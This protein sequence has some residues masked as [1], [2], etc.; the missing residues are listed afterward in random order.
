[1]APDHRDTILKPA[2]PDDVATA[3]REHFGDAAKYRVAMPADM[4]PDGTFGEVWFIFNETHLGVMGRLNGTPPVLL[5]RRAIEDVGELTVTPGLS[6]AVVEAGRGGVRERLLRVSHAR[7]KDFGDAVRL[8]NAWIKD[9]AWKP[10]LMDE[11]RSNC[12]KCG[13]PLP[14]TMT[15][16]P[17]CM[18]KR[19]M[20]RKVLAFLTPY[21]LEVSLLFVY[22]IA[23]TLVGLVNPYLGKIMVDDVIKPLQ[24]M[25]WLPLLA[26][27]MAVMYTL[28]SV[29]DILT[30]RTSS[31]IGTW[32]VYDVRARMF[33]R[34]QELSLSFHSKHTP[35]ALITRVNQDTGQLQ[36]LL[37]DFVPYGISSILTAIGI[38]A[39]LVYLSWFLTLFV[40]IPIV[41]MIVFVWK[42]FP[43][44]HVYWV[45][46]FER[47]SRLVSFVDNVV[48]GFRVVKVFAQERA[49][50][51]RFDRR[52]ADFRDA[53]YDAEVRWA[54]SMPLLH[55]IIMTSTPIVW[56]VGGMLA[57]QGRMT[58]GEIFAYTGYIGMFFRPVF[59]LTRLAQLI[60][61]TLAAAGR[62]FD[63]ID[64]EPEI[65]DAPD[66]VSM[67]DIK[68]EIE[69]R[70]VSFGYDAVKPVLQG[71]SL[72]IAPKEMVGLVGHSGAGKSTTI[73][74]ICRLFDVTSGQIL[75]DGVDVRKIKCNDLRR[76]I[77]L[78]MQET[79]LLHGTIAENIAYAR[80][81]AT[82]HDIIRAAKAAN[83]HDFIIAKPDGYDTE[84]AQGGSNLSAGEKQRLSIARAIL[85]DP[86]ILILDEATA[87]VDLETEKQIQEAIARMVKERTT[88][89][90]AHRLSTLR[91]ATR[92][93]V[94]EKGKV[95][96]QGTHE[97]L[98]K[99]ETG[100]YSRLAKLHQE[101]SNVRAVDR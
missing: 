45:R 89:A 75:V 99:N 29:V 12:P 8:I 23:N 55:V 17:H 20:I 44:F 15:V 82:T 65:A 36:A 83:A 94:M 73:N 60:P 95:V 25:G 78:V 43:R 67:P 101:T 92:L 69:L 56:L 30:G 2:L 41:G 96:E 97:E 42:V 37:V 18:D 57:F 33:Q 47:R 9:K 14:D 68:G 32:A 72:K 35:G 16:C 100:V 49:E 28:Q 61:N 31:R 85:C 81:E 3:A 71:V 87:S 76:Q 52:S 50:N 86:R 66:A 77:G 98:L 27:A 5:D 53:T 19:Q 6:S 11:R 38:L 58:L 79:F 90:I 34:L 10:E 74:L 13:R 63:I 40:L 93:V 70:D 64:T 88:I 59:I 80:P 48:N 1:M 51:D 54:T 24:N 91:N 22:M 39:L 62:V 21:K 7:Q 26:I 84:V 4:L 46:Y